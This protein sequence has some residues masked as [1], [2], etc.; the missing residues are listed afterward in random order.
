MTAAYHRL[1]LLFVDGI[2]LAAAGPDNPFSELE[3]PTIERLLAG[4]LTGENTGSIAGTG[5][6]SGGRL[7]AIDATLGVDGLP[8]SATGQTTLF[9]GVNAAAELGRHVS[10]YPGPRLKRLIDR[11]GL[12]RRVVEGGRRAT[13]ANAYSRRYLAD[14]TAGRARASVTTYS[15]LSAG[16]GF[17]DEAALDRGEAVAWDITRTWFRQRSGSAVDEI[18]SELAGRQLAALARRHDLTLYETFLTDLAGHR[19]MEIMPAAALTRLDGLLAGLLAAADD[20]LTVV[21]TSDH[22]NLE[23][24]SS[25][26]HSRNPVPLLVLGPGAEAFSG[27]RSLVDVTP[28]LLAALRVTPTPSPT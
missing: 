18:H 17:R 10:A 12:L 27:C 1:L 15:V 8:Q 19:R 14:L 22:G 24:D 9:T 25:R 2:G 20:E 11:H 21:V 26:R 23:D 4:P 13:F 7:S 6:I 16:L 28:A 5:A 3:L